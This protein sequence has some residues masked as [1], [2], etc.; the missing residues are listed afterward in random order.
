MSSSFPVH[1]RVA[2][3]FEPVREVFAANFTDD[4]EVGAGFAVFSASGEAL[5]DLWGGFSDQ[6]QS[7]PWQERTLVNVY[8]TTKGL[9]ALTFAT[10]VEDG[11]T[12][13]EAPVREIWPELRAAKD[14]LTVGQLLSHQG[15][16]AGV[17]QRLQVAD[18]YHWQKMIS[19]LEQQEPLWEP[20]T[21]SGY[22][23]VTW[24]YLAGELA[25]R[26]T[27]KTLGQLLAERLAGP[28]AA[29][30]Y[31][32]LPT[33]EMDR[34]APLIGPN[35]ARIRPESTDPKQP[36]VEKPE[37]HAA[38]L[39]NPV[40]RPF[41][42]ASSRDWQM[43]EIAASNGQANAAGIARIYAGVLG[44]ASPLSART[45]AALTAER[46]GMTPD[47]VLGGPVRRGAGVIL[48]TNE[49]YGPVAESFGHSGTGGSTGF[50]DPQH[51]IGVGYAMNQMQPNLPGDTRGGRLIRTLYQCLKRSE[52]PGGREA[53]NAAQSS[54]EQHGKKF[55]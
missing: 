29:A 47:L 51:R 43:A 30:F 39:Q 48:N 9:A 32:G 18:L 25:I 26:L 14:G 3:G 54:P 22:H 7:H 49:S 23:A 1:G 37:L 34:V 16:L 13:Y 28:F 31:L 19:L 11:L 44:A 46:V 4:V 20:G 38:A 40:I 10:L 17:S 52:L 53:G 50:A 35:R 24:G 6:A 15:G 8:S 27:G 42:D 2:P 21:Q 55:L 41:A 45:L 33:S 5:V 12:G 36:A